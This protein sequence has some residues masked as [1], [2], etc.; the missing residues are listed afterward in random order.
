MRILKYL[1]AIVEKQALVLPRNSYFLDA[2]MQDGNLCLWAMVPEEGE[3]VT[4]VI[5]LFGTGH[6]LP[7]DIQ[8]AHYIATAQQPPWVWHV[9]AQI[10]KGDA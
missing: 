6:P 7:N 4:L 10:L 2:Q 5:R 1:L 9:F 3:A 8:P